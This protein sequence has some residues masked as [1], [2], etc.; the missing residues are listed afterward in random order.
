MDGLR[1]AIDAEKT[2]LQTSFDAVFDG[3]R[4]R[5]D[6]ATEAVSR[7]RNIFN[8]LSNSLKSR[9]LGTME[10]G[11]FR[12]SSALSFL[13]SGDINDEIKLENALRV[14]SE[15]SEG[16]FSSF[17]DY[18]REFLQTSRVIADLENTAAIQLS[19]DEKAVVLLEQQ[20]EAN[21]AALDSQLA[22]LEQQ[23]QT[24]ID[25]YNALM[26]IDT[27]VKSVGDA[28]ATLRGAIQGLA[29]AQSAAKAAAAAPA[30]S[31]PSAPST[32]AAAVPDYQ[33]VKEGKYWVQRFSDGDYF[34][35]GHRNQDL[36]SQAAAT[37][38][39]L[40]AG[41]QFARGG[42]FDGGMR[43]VGE[44]GPELEVTGPSRIYSKQ[45]TKELLKGDSNEGEGLRAEVSEMRQELR[46]L[47]IAN[48]KYTKR[49]YDLYNK[50]DIDGL[51]AERT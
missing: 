43:L 12:R 10:E 1:R 22:A 51:P 20:I 50:W 47:L 35:T 45:Q 24:E 34:R 46:Q 38:A 13:Q 21:K 2:A 14:V 27:S 28:I 4:E 30:P 33:L 6:L 17:V 31:A 37:N 3:L 29:S 40:K 15:P 26:G 8:M 39:A 5:L 49:S 32:P 44:E 48:N 36:A 23:Y 41:Q 42:M 25:Q 9:S 18:A 7:S 16:L 19:A 11:M